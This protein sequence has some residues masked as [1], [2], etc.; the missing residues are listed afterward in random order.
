MLVSWL[1]LDEVPGRLT[2]AGGLL[3]PTGVAVSRS[4]PGPGTRV[5]SSAEAPPADA[6]ADAAGTDGSADTPETTTT[7]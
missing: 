4:G 3:C 5:A 1:L 2:L 6:A 7:T